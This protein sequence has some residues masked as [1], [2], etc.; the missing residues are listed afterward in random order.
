[1][2]KNVITLLFFLMTFSLLAHTDDPAAAVYR[3]TVDLNKVEN[4]RLKIELTVPRLKTSKTVFYLPKIVPGTYTNYNF[5]RFASDFKAFD[6]DGNEM[7]VKRLDINSWEITNAR[8]LARIS[9]LIDDSD[10]AGGENP[11]F[12]MSGTNIEAGK[13]FIINTHG[14]FGYFKGM[15]EVP[16]QIEFAHPDNFYGSTALSP[17]KESPGNTTYYAED[18]H[19][20]VDSP[21]MFSEPDT[22]TIQVGNTEVL[23]SVHAPQE[24]YNAGMMADQ[25]EA[26]LKATQDYF[27]G[28]LPVDR[29]AFIYY[30]RDPNE[31]Q[32]GTGALEHSHS[33]LY[34]M[35][36]YPPQFVL[37]ILRDISAHEFFHI[38][39]PL[40]IHSE[41]IHYFDFNQPEMS[42]HLWLYE[43]VTEYF[44]HHV[45]VNQGLISPEDFVEKMQGKIVTSQSQY[46][47]NLAFTKLS[48]GS[49]DEHQHEYGN[50]YEKGALIGMCLDIELR[51]LSNGQYGLRDLMKDLSD[52]FGKDQPFKDK[53]LFKE[54][55]KISYPE[56]KD[57]FKTYVDGDLP[58]P[59]SSILEQVGVT[60]T[61]SQKYMDFS[62]GHVALAPSETGGVV[63]AGIDQMDAMGKALGYRV[64]DELVTING[65]EIPTQGRQA[66][67]SSLKESFVEG[68]PV[69]VVVKRRDEAGELQT[70]A[71][72]ADA[73]KV[74]KK[75][76]PQLEL[77]EAA[78]AEQ[79]ALRNAWLK[80]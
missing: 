63:I 55:A 79:T 10:D 29:Y 43:G 28:Q 74:E 67:F 12:G 4:D 36:Y 58:L 25:L 48:K 41:E 13:N 18:Y 60:Y 57:F 35:P 33:S 47:D 70:I 30:F 38:L 72:K 42:Q 45:Q 19:L 46:N 31:M 8:N 34:Y 77:N 3:Y 49:L 21:M 52:K 9:Y 2:Q 1:M 17:I 27:G 20:L 65:G 6:A 66:F 14:F 68:Q 40:N 80:N 26:L 50:V 11:V 64:G 54:I 37:P 61:P 39:T 73:I 76:N 7:P 71:L 56:I 53:K 32:V 51:R 23:I 24:D 75:T 78:T 69:E 62:L 59:Y 5:G 16:F 15:K 22:A 44:A